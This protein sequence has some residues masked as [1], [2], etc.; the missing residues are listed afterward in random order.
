MSDNNIKRFASVIKAT[1]A[2]NLSLSPNLISSVA[3]VSFSFTIGIIPMFN[4]DLNVDLI[5]K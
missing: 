5:F 3:T 1:C 2:A 4:N